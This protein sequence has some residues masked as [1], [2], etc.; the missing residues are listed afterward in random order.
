MLA[1]A[2]N[3]GNADQQLH[4]PARLGRSPRAEGLVRR[5][6]RALGILAGPLRKAADD[7]PGTGRVDRFEASGGAGLLASDVVLSLDRQSRLDGLQRLGERLRVGRIGKIG[8]GFV[9]EFGKQDGATSGRKSIS[10]PSALDCPAPFD[11][12][13]EWRSTTPSPT[14]QLTAAF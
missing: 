8:Q 12:L 14:S 13:A 2:Q 5:G 10:S 7:L 6:D 3:R 9:L 4:P 1:A 11:R